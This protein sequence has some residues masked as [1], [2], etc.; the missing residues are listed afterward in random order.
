MVIGTDY[1]FIIH[2]VTGG[3]SLN[4]Y[5]YQYGTSTGAILAV[6]HNLKTPVRSGM[7]V[8]IPDGFTDVSSLPS[9]D[10][11]Q[12]QE[13][14]VTVEALAQVLGV[15]PSGLEYYNAISVGENLQ[16]GDWVL[17]PYG[18]PPYNKDG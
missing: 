14:S 18:Q 16:S 10:V 12:V 1:K 15:N 8:V 11:Y 9:F 17:V 4:Q 5:A 3:E 7:L 2:Q 6:N 13:V